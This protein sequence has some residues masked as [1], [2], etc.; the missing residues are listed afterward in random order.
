MDARLRRPAREVVTASSAKDQRPAPDFAR[1]DC[2]A[3]L[4]RVESF[5]RPRSGTDSA[6]RR[7]PRSYR[8]SC[9]PGFLDF[10]A[11]DIIFLSLS[12]SGSVREGALVASPLGEGERMKVRVGFV[13]QPRWSCV[14]ATL[15]P[16][17]GKGEATHARTMSSLPQKSLSYLGDVENDILQNR[18]ELRARL[19][20][21][22]QRS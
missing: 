13:E 7:V 4:E 9:A 17:L 14:D 11:D 12:K 8:R 6:S 22:L 19:R 5:L 16:L 15:T 2:S 20:R 10:A 18:V 3:A 1:L 21:R